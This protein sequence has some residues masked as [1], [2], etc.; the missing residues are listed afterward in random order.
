[1]PNVRPR[2]LLVYASHVPDVHITVAPLSPV[3]GCLPG[4]WVLRPWAYGIPAGVLDGILFSLVTVKSFRH[5][6][7][8][9]THTP[10]LFVVMLADSILYFGSVFAV[11]VANLL[12]WEIG[13]VCPHFCESISCV[14]AVTR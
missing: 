2:A 5:F 1:M 6:L 14:D 9:Q 3:S 4:H 8:Q 13:G 12:M 10:E 11:L 7:S